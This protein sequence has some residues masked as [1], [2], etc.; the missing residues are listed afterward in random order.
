MPG[1][2]NWTVGYA[3]ETDI[4]AYLPGT[5]TPK[6][7]GW[8]AANGGGAQAWDMDWRWGSEMVPL[9]FTSVGGADGPL[10]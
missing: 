10:W 4:G 9:Q 2:M 6:H 1:T 3:A 5:G 8:A 7:D